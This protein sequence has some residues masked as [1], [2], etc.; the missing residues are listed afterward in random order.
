MQ[1]APPKISIVFPSYN[2]E[3]FLKRNLESI[4]LLDNLD[5]IELVIIDNRSNDSTVNVIKDFED[6]INIKLIKNHLNEGFAEACNLGVSNCNGDFVFITNQDVIFPSNFFTKLKE[7]YFEYK[8][9]HEIIISPALIFETGKI[10]YFGAKNHLLGFSYTPELG[11]IMPP[12][13]II[14]PTQR[15]SGGT[16]FIKKDFFQQM[17]GFEKEF[18]MYYED[19]DFSLRL[20]RNGNTIYTTN[21]PYL[22][23]QKKCQIMNKLQYFFLERNRFL[24][25]IKNFEDIYKI[26]PYLLITEIIMLVHSLFVKKFKLRL[27]IYCELLH[28]FKSYKR[29]REE[30][31]KKYSLIPYNKLSR[32]LD[33]ILLGNLQKLKVFKKILSLFNKLI[34]YA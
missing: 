3:R 16:L 10:H 13:R 22:I 26:M 21:D 8:I 18:F 25:I 2:G 9:K 33:P 34:K 5:E 30:S 14:K 7:I 32:K 19:T 24:I 17:G 29:L 4:K 31:K 23:H 28:K 6:L 27:K 20:M 11:E 12:K 1:L 15:F